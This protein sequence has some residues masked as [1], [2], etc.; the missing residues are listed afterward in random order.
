M[1]AITLDNA[2]RDIPMF[3]TKLLR[4]NLTD[5]M[6]RTDNWIFKSQKTD[7][8]DRADLPRVIIDNT[9]FNTEYRGLS[10][11]SGT[12]MPG[13]INIEIVIYSNSIRYRDQIADDIR[14]ILFNSSSEDDEGDSIKSNHLILRRCSEI[15]E[16]FFASHSR[17]IR[18]KRLICEF[19]YT[20]VT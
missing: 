12:L 15:V 19:R 16:D 1:V 5:P 2:G 11:N 17:I 18:S 8:I 14:D 13:P 9:E 10:D 7:P 6:S 20:G 3:I 4:N